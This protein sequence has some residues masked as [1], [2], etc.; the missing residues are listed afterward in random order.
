MIALII[1]D[2]AGVRFVPGV[3]PDVFHVFHL[4]EGGVVTERAVERLAATNATGL[5]SDNG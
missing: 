3:V 2:L 4:V 1:A 5:P